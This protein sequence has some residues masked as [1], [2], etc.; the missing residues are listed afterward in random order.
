MCLLFFAFLFISI[1]FCAL[2][3]ELM[4]PPLPQNTCHQNTKS[5]QS[6]AEVKAA[7]AAEKG[8]EAKTAAPRRGGRGNGPRR[9]MMWRCPP[10]WPPPLA[11]SPTSPCWGLDSD[12]W[13]PPL[14]PKSTWGMSPL[15]WARR[16]SASCSRGVGRW[17]MCSSLRMPKATRRIRLWSTRAP[18][19]QNR[20][21][22][23]WMVLGQ[24][25]PYRETGSSS[26]TK[27]L[28]WLVF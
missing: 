21:L 18:R 7:A 17:G 5:T 25:L 9:G 13:L 20:P 6:A 24:S 3:Q 1:V 16:K 12:P 8:A 14:S 23:L 2:F 28:F 22:P 15:G 4:L 19:Q 27:F 26:P 10:S 11:P